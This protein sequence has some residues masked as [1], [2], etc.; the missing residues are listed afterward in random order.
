MVLRL[1]VRMCVCVCV[2]VSLSLCVCVCVRAC[3]PL[4]VVACWVAALD[5]RTVRWSCCEVSKGCVP[6]VQD[7]EAATTATG[8]PSL[9]RKD[10][11]GGATASDNVSAPILLAQGKTDPKKKR[12]T[13]THKTSALEVRP[14]A[15]SRQGSS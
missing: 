9:L 14:P 8:R 4:F 11:H 2:C 15:L 5:R 12:E 7:M 1:C 13:K 3:V 10:G 6:E